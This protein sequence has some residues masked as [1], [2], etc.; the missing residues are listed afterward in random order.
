MSYRSIIQNIH[1]CCY[2]CSMKKNNKYICLVFALVLALFSL[3]SCQNVFGSKTESS[4]IIGKWLYEKDNG[5]GI[6]LE[7]NDDG[8]YYYAEYNASGKTTYE[9]NGK[10]GFTANRLILRG[11]DERDGER[12]SIF[13][14][15]MKNSIDQLDLV[16]K[17]T[18]KYSF[19]RVGELLAIP[20]D[21]QGEWVSDRT[22]IKISGNDV[23]VSLGDESLS[24][25]LENPEEGKLI[26]TFSQEGFDAYKEVE[27]FVRNNSL[28]LIFPTLRNE[29]MVF[30]S[31]TF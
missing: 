27:Y 11:L 6:K 13:A 24:A 9:Y 14:V 29:T 12:Y 19:K 18:L 2:P 26:L 17:M 1:D 3:P 31:K 10:Y 28:Y 21:I 23:L 15:S 22:S 4:N 5:V 8:T 7:L 25:K 20:L 16:P 30:T